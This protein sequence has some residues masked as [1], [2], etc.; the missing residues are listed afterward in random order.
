RKWEEVFH[1]IVDSGLMG[2][3]SSLTPF[4]FAN[5]VVLA[6]LATPPSPAVMAQWIYANK[7]YGTFASF[8]VMGF[9][10]ERSASPAA[11][12]AAFICVY[13][14]LNYWLGDNDTKL[15]LF[16]LYPCPDLSDLCPR[17]AEWLC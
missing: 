15:L 7:D 10:L 2:F 3:G 5:N 11:V 6:G 1:W 14:W 17:M 4:Q 9:K 8:H 13:C 16:V 12:R